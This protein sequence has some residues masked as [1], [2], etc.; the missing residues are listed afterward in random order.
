MCQITRCHPTTN[1]QPCQLDS[2]Q[3]RYQ[4]LRMFLFRLENDHTIC[5]AS[6]LQTK[7]SSLPDPYEFLK[8]AL[9]EAVFIQYLLTEYTLCCGIHL[10]D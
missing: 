5:N 10:M 9:L 3:C 1:L 2:G 7:L 8:H 6:L 4:I